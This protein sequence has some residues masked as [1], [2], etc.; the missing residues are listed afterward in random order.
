MS[1]LITYYQVPVYIVLLCSLL[2]CM[3]EDM[4]FPYDVV[5]VRGCLSSPLTRQIGIKAIKK[6]F[7]Y[8]CYKKVGE[9]RASTLLLL[10]VRVW[11]TLFSHTLG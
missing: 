10:C 7:H 6:S 4:I 9:G 3:D 1:P 11:S 8:L 5:N 2:E